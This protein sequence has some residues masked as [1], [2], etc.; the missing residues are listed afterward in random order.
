VRLKAGIVGIWGKA[1]CDTLI[2]DQLVDQ[3]LFDSSIRHRPYADV[4]KKQA[5]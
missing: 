5:P 4:G 2:W 3:G 1:A